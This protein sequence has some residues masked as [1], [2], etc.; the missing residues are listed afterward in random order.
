MYFTKPAT[1]DVCLLCSF[2]NCIDEFE[3]D[4][5]DKLINNPEA[6]IGPGDNE[7]LVKSLTPGNLVNKV[8]TNRQTRIYIEQWS[9]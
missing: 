3:K 9:I 6:D 4:T 2:I 5:V 8:R 7:T 1:D